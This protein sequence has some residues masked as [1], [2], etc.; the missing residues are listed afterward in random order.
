MSS[1]ES[2][3]APNEPAP[4]TIP[5][6][7]P[8]R[9]RG[10]RAGLTVA[11]LF[12]LLLLLPSLS[13]RTFLAD[14]DMIP[15]YW[16]MKAT[17][18]SRAGS[19]F[20]LW[21]PDTFGGIS[22]PA[23]LIQQP[24]YPPNLLFR[25]LHVHT[26][27]GITWYL[28][29]HGLVALV[30]A[31]L[32][33]R[34]LVSASAAALA[35]G[36]FLLSGFMV[37][38]L[39]SA[40]QF[41]CA[42]AWA[43]L[44]LWC[45]W[46]LG[47][48]LSWRRWALAALVAPV[49]LYAGDLQCFITLSIAGGALI[50]AAGRSRW[51]R[52]VL[53]GSALML[54]VSALIA[55]QVW[56]TREVL[57]DLLREAQL[58]FL[59]RLVWSFHPARVAEFF[60]PRLFGP[61]F[62][63]GYW[64]QFT[65]N[66]PSP[67]NYFHSAY[68]GALLPALVWAALRARPAPTLVLIGVFQFL[69]WFAFGKYSF[70]YDLLVR[71]IPGWSLFRYPERMMLLPTLCAALL[72]GLGAQEICA[73]P[74]H[75]RSRLIGG[76]V[77]LGMATLA[78]LAV[79]AP[80]DPWNNGDARRA[81]IVSLSQLA[82]LGAAALAWARLPTSTPAAPLLLLVI[83]LADISAANR[84]MTGQIRNDPFHALP[85]VCS[86]IVRLSRG[87]GPLPPRTAWRLFL[88]EGAEEAAQPFLPPEWEGMIPPWGA[89]RWKEYQWGYGNV[90][91]LCGLRY[92][93]GMTSLSPLSFRVLWEAAGPVR[94]LGI[95]STRFIIT[96]PNRPLALT[97]GALIRYQDPALGMAIVELPWA[98]P[99]LYRPDEVK[100]IPTRE[101]IRQLPKSSNLLTR[102]MA[103]L[104]PGSVERVHRRGSR[105]AVTAFR[106]DNAALSFAIEQDQPG[107]WIL[108]DTFDRNWRAWVDGGPAVIERA[109]LRHRAI[110]IPAGAHRVHMQYRPIR[111]LM[112]AGAALLLACALGALATWTRSRGEHG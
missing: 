81:I 78:A 33:A 95:S 62:E 70:G 111:V 13:G 73:R 108:T 32:L 7:P 6:P 46:R 76:S 20:L 93:V 53:L 65:I 106:E 4:Q 112:L 5:D 105:G 59:G 102:S 23:D 82:I 39:A 85:R 16:P 36:T 38:N 47:D 101:L 92:S 86:E 87:T 45:F 18:W 21:N 48:E 79:A 17:F 61:P 74:R 35:A 10:G 27:T 41:H 75:E 98:V 88:D 71:T 22:Y 1:P 77:A 34:R 9:L 19:L 51:R 99:R 49:P 40:L 94:A 89:Q 12:W 54:A 96:A 97:P 57:P 72:A 24:F 103:T 30:G 28:A 67:S 56:A 8:V 107:Y 31:F 52:A 109:D 68:V 64:G 29:L 91:N 84:P 69:T 66:G 55:P 37:A 15:N 44:V 11:A 2:S 50:L 100:R 63:P 80:G 110:W 58:N 42:Y 60:V 26:P 43:P 25:L 90:L 83:H 3:S 104:E 14:R